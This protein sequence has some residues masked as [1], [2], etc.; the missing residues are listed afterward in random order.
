MNTNKLNAWYPALFLLGCGIGGLNAWAA[1]DF[2][3]KAE[4]S[5]T[6]LVIAAP[7]L[8]LA[9]NIIPPAAKIAWQR[10]P[11]MASAMLLTVPFCAWFLFSTS[12]ERLHQTKATQSA[13]NT[14][15]VLASTRAEAELNEAK[16]KYNSL[17]KEIALAGANVNCQKQIKCRA[18][19]EQAVSLQDR[20]AKAEAE[21][22]E[23]QSTAT[24]ESRWKSPD[25]LLPALVEF[26]AFV[27][28]WFGLSRRWIDR[29]PMPTIDELE[30]KQH[31]LNKAVER[32]RGKIAANS[33]TAIAAPTV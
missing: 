31:R 20:I 3:L 7:V 29:N 21:L 18:T 28:T 2:Y 9:I 27:L 11:L 24:S 32:A 15:V 8:A 25:W 4:G 19:L 13:K 6:Y 33:K 30:L 10:D 22:K 26:M 5:I 17:D 14:S 23:L 12:A 1:W 16:A